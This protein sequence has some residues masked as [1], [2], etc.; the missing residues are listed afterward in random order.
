[1]QQVPLINLE[2]N[3]DFLNEAAFSE[4]YRAGASTLAALG[5]RASD[6]QYDAWRVRVALWAGQHAAGLQGDFVECG[7]HTGFLSRALM[8]YLKFE[9]LQARRFYLVDTFEGVPADQ[10][11]AEEKE[12]GVDERAR[13]LYPHDVYELCRR[14]FAAYPNAVLVRGRV[15]EVLASLPE[16]PVAYL[17]IDMNCVAPEVA[18]VRH[19]WPRLVPGAVVLFDDYGV[20]G[21]ENQ[22]RAADALAAELGNPLFPLPSGQALIVKLP[23]GAGR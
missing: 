7:V 3:S 21:H 6:F 19:F 15:P 10:F 12:A 22:K 14:N 8:S 20:L 5:E 18:A 4:A 13:E 17:S 1:M 23:S 2:V 11:S 16:G 9:Q